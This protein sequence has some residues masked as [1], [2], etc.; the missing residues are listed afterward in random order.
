[1][2]EAGEMVEV[3]SNPGRLVGQGGPR[4]LDGLGK[5][6]N[7]VW[8]GISG[9]TGLGP[10]LFFVNQTASERLLRTTYALRYE[11]K[12]SETWYWLL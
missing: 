2:S 7:L 1:M 10:T 8:L 12:R 6:A 11:H 5:L 3:R 9:T 4:C